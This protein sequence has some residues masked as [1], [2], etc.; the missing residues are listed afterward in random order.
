VNRESIAAALVVAVVTIAAHAPAWRG[1]F[2]SDDISEI[3]EN[4]AIRVLWP[5]GV[6]M[7]EGTPMPHRPL[8]YYTFA[9]NYALHGLD[10][11]GYHAVNLAIHLAN[12][13]L[14][15]WVA[16][17]V[18]RRLGVHDAVGG[19]AFAA[20]TL[21]L[22]HPLV[23][24]AVDYVYQRIES[25]AALA[26]L[27]T[28]GCFLRAAS[29]RRPAKWLAA[30]VAA[31]ATG[32][33]CKEHVA[34]AP[35][36]A[37]L[38]DWLTGQPR[39]AA[40]W[41]SLAAAVRARPAYYAALFAT[42]LVAI[43]LVLLQR[44]RFTDFKQTLAGPLLYAANQP[45]VIGEYLARAIW[46]HPLCIDWYR[47]PARSAAALAPGI[48]ALVIALA[49]AAWAVV[50]ARG[51]ALAILLFLALL[52]PTSSFLPV[53]DLMV[54]HRMYLPLLV[55][56]VGLCGASYRMIERCMPAACHRRAAIGLTAVATVALAVTTWNRCHVYQSRLVMWADVVMKAPGNPRAWQTLALELWQAG[57][58]DRAL[59]AVD[60][61]LAIV[62]DAAL[63]HLTRA[64]ILADLGRPADAIAAA[65]RA[66]A[67]DA[68]LGDARRLRAAALEALQK[69]EAH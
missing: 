56:C 67:L 42:P 15:W 49:I 17:E 61:S 57:I 45:L 27:G 55:V 35:V 28:V 3:A 63:S 51:L 39:N 69:P 33:L 65:D 52:A 11:R 58:T 8:P 13:W 22:V 20:A 12:G 26:I 10:P 2:V 5:P 59:E 18:L 14:A 24:Q 43:G 37:L 16:R 54:E 25:L 31:S 40:P 47:L 21:W 66:L 34:A 64:G 41:R 9:A 4:P 32:M 62:P 53:N 7:F 30:S 36:A 38:F 46:P 29:S 19:I 23:T 1:A 68:S 60:R 48:L 44:D 6:P 50:H